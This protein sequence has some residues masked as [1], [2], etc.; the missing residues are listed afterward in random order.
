VSEERINPCDAINSALKV[1]RH[2]GFIVTHSYQV[3]S[4]YLFFCADRHTDRHIDTWTLSKHTCRQ[5]V[6]SKLKRKQINVRATKAVIEAREVNRLT[7]VPAVCDGTEKESV[8]QITTMLF[9][10][11][12]TDQKDIY[13]C[14]IAA[15]V[16]QIIDF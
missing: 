5:L 14:D 4:V 11:T 2:Q 6:Q 1:K 13:S 3:T 7:E 12:D 8:Q 10:Y 15:L 16:I 9:R